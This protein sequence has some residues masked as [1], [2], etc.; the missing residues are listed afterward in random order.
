MK[1]KGS[2]II[3]YLEEEGVEVHFTNLRVVDFIVRDR[4]AV[5]RRTLDEFIAELDNKMVYRTAPEF[6]RSFSDP[7]YVVEGATPGAKM[8]ASN[9]GR[10]GI[11]YLT[12]MNRIPI[13]FTNSAEETARYLS[14]IIK[15]AEYAP[16]REQVVEDDDSQQ[17]LV[18]EDGAS[19]NGTAR[20]AG[21]FKLRSLCALP[22]ITN[23]TAQALLRR[24]GSLKSI[25]DADENSLRKAKGVGPKRAKSLQ[26]A[27]NS[28]AKREKREKRPSGNRR[29]PASHGK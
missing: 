19:S 10:A 21:D 17:K 7:L 1:Q 28:G 22:G 2:E 18:H 20:E 4:F 9:A 29:H 24:F 13:L 11:T 6:K 5:V 3:N 8:S 16:A 15:Q 26:N 14:L 23:E 25:Y 27:I 12:I